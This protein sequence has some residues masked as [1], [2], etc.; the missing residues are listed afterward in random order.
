MHTSSFVIVSF[1]NLHFR[2]IL[3]VFFL[4]LYIDKDKTESGDAAT[5]LEV[6]F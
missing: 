5:T 3:Y 4:S 6:R 2:Y 1:T